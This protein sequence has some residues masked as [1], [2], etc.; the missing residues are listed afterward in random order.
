MFKASH[1]A[2]KL[3]AA[4]N[5]LFCYHPH[6]VISAGVLGAATA[7]T[8]FDELFPGLTLSVNTLPVNWYVS[9]SST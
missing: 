6:G 4:R 9:V 8:G 7:A 2:V 1:D 3:D 5:F